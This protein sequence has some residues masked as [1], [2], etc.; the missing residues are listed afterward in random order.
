MLLWTQDGHHLMPLDPKAIART[1]RRNERIAEKH[2]KKLGVRP[3]RLD[4]PGAGRKRPDFL[5]WEGDTPLILCEVKTIFS[6][7]YDSVEHL[8]HS[9]LD[10]RIF[11]GKARSV[12]PVSDNY[13]SE[14]SKAAS[15]YREVT[16]D[17]LELAGL[18]FVV[19]VFADLIADTPLLDRRQPEF[20]ELSGILR[21]EKNR[22]Q[23]E[24][25]EKIPVKRFQRAVIDG[26]L[27]LPPPEK[28]WRLLENKYANVPVPEHIAMMCLRGYPE[29]P[30]DW[31]VIG[32]V[33]ATIRRVD[34]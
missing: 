16:E 31:N 5:L 28:E 21:L 17:R 23:R 6:A 19:V 27:R 7:G 14:F 13:R 1:S 2:L 8:H 4:N 3:E 10:P 32:P 34:Q 33:P 18:P 25:A 30:E 22:R 29:D 24:A 15:Q 11:D 9:A 20:P 26:N 12:P